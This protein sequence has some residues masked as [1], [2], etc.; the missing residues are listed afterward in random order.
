MKEREE[1][2]MR[3]FPTN[4]SH[5]SVCAKSSSI[6]LVGSLCYAVL[7]LCFFSFKSLCHTEQYRVLWVYAWKHA[8]SLST[9]Y[10]FQS[11]TLGVC[12][13]ISFGAFDCECGA[14]YCYCCWCR[15]RRVRCS[16][17]CCCCLWLA[18]LCL[19]YAKCDIFSHLLALRLYECVG[20]VSHI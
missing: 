13:Y 5:N 2:W 19:W 1:Y 14:T 6:S 4:E 16:C 7:C 12:R 18:L 11:I 9:V 8:V 15:C 3:V 10:H 17:C 20:V